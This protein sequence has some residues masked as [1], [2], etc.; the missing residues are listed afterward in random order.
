MLRLIDYHSPTTQAMNQ[1]FKSIESPSH[2]E[3]T[4]TSNQTVNVKLARE[5]HIKCR[6]FP[7]MVVDVRPTVGQDLGTLYGLKNFLV[8]R[9]A[10]ST[11]NSAVRIVIIP[12]G[13]IVTDNLDTV[14]YHLY[15]VDT[16]LGCLVA[17]DSM[18]SHLFKIYLHALTA[19]CLPD[20]LTG[21]TGTEQALDSLRSATLG[22]SEFELP[23][24]HFKTVTQADILPIPLRTMQQIEWQESLPSYCQH[25]EFHSAVNSILQHWELSKEQNS[26]HEDLRKRASIRGA[27][28]Q[29]S[30]YGG[31]VNTRIHDKE[32]IAREL[33]DET[34]E[35]N[36][37]ENESIFK[38]WI[39][40][41]LAQ[42]P[43]GKRLVLAVQ[44]LPKKFQVT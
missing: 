16:L 25:W 13:K 41:L 11:L 33:T 21:L 3:L 18:R 36:Q 12:H 43:H 32:Y 15:T 29:P 17:N 27:A 28:Y 23:Q 2:L 44:L 31:N 8:L 6:N 4:L 35:D 5:S 26:S 22:P 1:L 37:L 24:W 19:Y 42:Q 30:E 10:A 14:N 7:E 39:P 40:T 20:P 9:E 38:H 34:M